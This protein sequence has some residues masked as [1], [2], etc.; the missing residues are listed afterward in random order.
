[1]L[2]LVPH[3]SSLS[4]SSCVSLVCRHLM[5]KLSSCGSSLLWTQLP[6]LEYPL[7]YS[8]S[9]DFT[10][11]SFSSNGFPHNCLFLLLKK[12]SGCDPACL[13]E[14]FATYCSPDICQLLSMWN[15]F[16]ACFSSF[17]GP[18]DSESAMLIDRLQPASCP[19]HLKVCLWAFSI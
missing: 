2:L 18:Q 11:L 14:I 3:G 12:I 4:A 13:V 10:Y 9:C 15:R 8:S 6:V 19:L 16:C 5:L 7:L 1:M 17:L